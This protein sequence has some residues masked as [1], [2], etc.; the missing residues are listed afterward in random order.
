MIMT[1]MYDLKVFML[2]F[3]ILLIFL[4]NC[5]NV[6]NINPQDEYQDLNVMLRNI[7]SALRIST[8]DFDFT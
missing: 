8:G 7:F 6:L 5:L 1:C 4:G 3:V 2:F